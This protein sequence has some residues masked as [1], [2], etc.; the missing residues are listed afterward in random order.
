MTTPP[1]ARTVITPQL[2]A[3]WICA[4][5]DLIRD[6]DKPDE[7]AI[8]VG[9]WDGMADSARQRLSEISLDLLT[10]LDDAG[11]LSKVNRTLIPRVQ[12]D[13]TGRRMGTPAPEG[14][15]AGSAPGCTCGRPTTL[16]IV[17]RIDGHCYTPGRE[18]TD[19]RTA[20]GEYDNP[21]TR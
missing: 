6:P 9:P 10:L 15:P 5:G 1:D 12:R 14:S 18:S 17:H 21:P 2:V 11:A 13:H 8:A 4:L 16:G 20:L 7:R 3:K 19:L